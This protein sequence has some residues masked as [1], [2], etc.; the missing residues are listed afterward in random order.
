MQLVE[1]HIIKK[2][3]ATFKLLDDLCFKSKNIYN[4]G[5]FLIRQ[6]FI[7]NE[8]YLNYYSVEKK[9]KSEYY[10]TSYFLM[11][12]KEKTMKIT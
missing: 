4:M 3:N 9:L 10:I 6:E 12:N 2:S 11:K 5:L 7:H 8:K 1:K